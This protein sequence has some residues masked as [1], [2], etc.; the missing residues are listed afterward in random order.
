M[1]G[2]TESNDSVRAIQEAIDD[3]INLID[4]APAYGL[5]L[6]ER[7]VGEA[8]RGRRDQV[9]LATKCGL[10]WHSQQGTLMVH[11]DGTPVYRFLGAASIRNEVE[12]SLARLG[13]DYIDLYQTHWQDDTTP[14][15]ETMQ[16]LLALKQEGKIRAIGVSN[17]GISHLDAYRAAGQLD[18]D[19]EK[20]SMLDRRAE[21]S[22][23]PYAETSQLAF[24]AYSP[25]ALGLLTGKIGPDRQFPSTDL[26]STNPRFAPDY[27]LAVQEVLGRMQPIADDHEIG[28][29]QLVLAWTAAVPGITHV[30]AGARNPEQALENSAAGDI[31]LSDHELATITALVDEF[32][33]PPARPAR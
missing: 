27:R 5:G 12:Q 26:R 25:L 3:G 31:K 7:I 8:I 9:V 19:Q 30:L 21:D 15:A 20:F 32:P 14:V 28:L 11:Q 23:L 17:A 4:T 13:T 2:G 33:P 22:L 29:A 18:S 6:S 1:W 16:T 10:Q 24:L